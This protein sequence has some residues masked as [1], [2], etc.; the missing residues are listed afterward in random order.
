MVGNDFAVSLNVVIII[1]SDSYL[2]D[3]DLFSKAIGLQN[4]KLTMMIFMVVATCDVY[5]R[6]YQSEL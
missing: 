4:Q 1:Y 5:P 3:S 6:G 2:R